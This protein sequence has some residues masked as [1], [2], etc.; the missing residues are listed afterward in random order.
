M[1]IRAVCHLASRPG[2]SVN[3]R[4]GLEAKINVIRHK[5]GTLNG[6]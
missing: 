3:E 2:R 1:V 5:G 4:P 6:P